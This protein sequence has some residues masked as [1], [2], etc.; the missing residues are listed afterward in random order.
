MKQKKEKS[1]TSI[2]FTAIIIFI[3]SFIPDILE[4]RRHVRITYKACYSNIRVLQGAVE[5]YNMDNKEKMT[6][7]DTNT[8]FD[9]KY[10]KSIQK[11]PEP[12]CKYF[13]TGDLTE[14]GEIC[15]ELHG[16]L[17]AEGNPDVVRKKEKQLR[18]KK[19]KEGLTFFSIHAIPSL[20]YLFF[21]LL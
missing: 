1:Y 8:L 10:I 6:D 14:D 21:A 7:L 5:L 17:I 3:I 9:N 15:C 19:I 4:P 12:E 16:G 13:V 11:G 18:I 2:I 20:I